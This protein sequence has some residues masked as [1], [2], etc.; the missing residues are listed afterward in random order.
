MYAGVPLTEKKCNGKVKARMSSHI[1]GFNSGDSFEFLFRYWVLKKI[2]TAKQ[3]TGGS[4]N[5]M[6]ILKNLKLCELI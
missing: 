3:Q 1:N 6:K 5:L 2:S 4:G